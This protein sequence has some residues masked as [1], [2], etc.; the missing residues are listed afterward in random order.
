MRKF[1]VRYMSKV[2]QHFCDS[3]TLAD[4][5]Q[6]TFLPLV[7]SR[8]HVHALPQKEHKVFGLDT[9]GKH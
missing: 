7:E 8:G 2:Y 5:P 6:A 1:Y 9:H 4:R 3:K